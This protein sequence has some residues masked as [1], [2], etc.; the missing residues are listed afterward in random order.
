MYR[1]ARDISRELYR[2]ESPT[3]ALMRQMANSTAARINDRY[4]QL[5]EQFDED[6]GTITWPPSE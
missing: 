5:N 4:R 3:C 1:R 2:I 6:N